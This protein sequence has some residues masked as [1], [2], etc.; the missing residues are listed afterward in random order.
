MKRF[1]ILRGG[2]EGF[3]SLFSTI[4]FMLLVTVITIG[5]IQITATE[6]QQALNNDLS[7]SALAS[8]QSGL[9]DGKR[10]VLKYFS[11][12]NPVDKTTYYTQMTAPTAAN[13]NSITGSQ[14]GTDLGLST[15]GN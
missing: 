3:V 8:A 6:Q 4:F 1:M 11:L 2:E 7:S 15:T 9:E 12:T 13:C 14:V 10:A 5:F